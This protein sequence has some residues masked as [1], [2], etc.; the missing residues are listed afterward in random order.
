M[1][2][3]ADGTFDPEVILTHRFKSV[4]SLFSFYFVMVES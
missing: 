2:K 3:I 4:A 1:G